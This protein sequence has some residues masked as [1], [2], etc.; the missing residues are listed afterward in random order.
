MGPTIEDR[1][2]RIR[3]FI[4]SGALLAFLLQFGCATHVSGV[5]LNTVTNQPLTTAVLTVGRPD[6]NMGFVR[7]PVDANGHFDFT[8]SPLDNSYL[9]VWNGLGDSGMVYRKID[10]IEFGTDMKVLFSP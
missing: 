1:N 9:F 6:N 7:H 3:A 4:L 10:R 5:V 8:F 2:M